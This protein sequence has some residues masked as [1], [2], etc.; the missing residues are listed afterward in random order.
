MQYPVIS[1]SHDNIYNTRKAVEYA[2]AHGITRGIHLGDFGAPNQILKKVML[3][4]GIHWNT[5]FGNG[6]GAKATFVTIALAH[7][8]EITASLS[9]WQE[10]DIDGTKIF[11]T[12]YP[13]LARIAAETG[14]Y[15]AVFHGHNHRAHSEVL[16]SGTLLANPG[17]IIGQRTGTPSLGVWDTETNT[18]EIIYLDDFIVAR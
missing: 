13:D 4:Q 3:G 17:E 15:A 1:D 5:V 12:H 9:E 11:I 7:P 10:L 6:D 8:D 14:R 18:F 2:V 16:E